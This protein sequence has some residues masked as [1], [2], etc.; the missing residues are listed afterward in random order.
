M[1]ELARLLAAAGAATAAFGLGLALAGPTGRQARL[2]R[3]S[4]AGAGKVRAGAAG[5]AAAGARAAGAGTFGGWRGLA[6]RVPAS[7][8]SRLWPPDAELRSALAGSGLEPADVRLAGIFCGLGG[9]LGLGLL[10][11]P[12]GGP[13]GVAVAALGAAA[14]LSPSL[15]LRSVL[16]RHRAAVARELPKAAELLTLGAESGLGLL[17]AAR[18]AAP[19]LDGPVGRALRE[20]LAEIDAGRETVSALRGVAS[21]VGGAAASLFAASV[22]QG[23]ELGTP[24]ARVL[25]AQADALRTKRRQALEARIAGLSLKLT[26]VTVL[27]FVP[28]LFVLSVLPNLM[29]FLRG[30]W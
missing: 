20:A 10:Y 26:L 21:R 12:R 3:L 18:L 14:L 7:L 2:E 24:I 11:V 13:P 9:L 4:G 17:E 16:A 28:A 23:L 30:Q 29:A 27:L 15:W 6:R 1:E 5:A 22:A 25:R 8:R 19:L